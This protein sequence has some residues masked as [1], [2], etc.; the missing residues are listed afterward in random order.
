[1]F[2]LWKEAPIDCGGSQSRKQEIESDNSKFTKGRRVLCFIHKGL[3]E[4]SHLKKIFIA[5]WN[6]NSCI[7]LERRSLCPSI[8]APRVVW[9]RHLGKGVGTVQADSLSRTLCQAPVLH[10]RFYFPVDNFVKS[11]SLNCQF[12]CKMGILRL[13]ANLAVESP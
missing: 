1:M 5:C 11:G 7:R 10:G 8:L 6:K 12:K 2:Y 13:K 4:Y 3:K 9:C